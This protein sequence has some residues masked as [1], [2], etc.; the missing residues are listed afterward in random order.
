MCSTWD[1]NVLYLGRK[2]WWDYC[3]SSCS[4][5][6]GKT[7]STPSLNFGL[8]FDN[9]FVCEDE[10]EDLE[11]DLCVLKRIG[12][13]SVLFLQIHV[14]D[15]VSEILLQLCNT[16]R[17]LLT[18]TKEN[19]G[20]QTNTTEGTPLGILAV[21]RGEELLVYQCTQV[22]VQPSLEKLHFYPYL[23]E[24]TKIWKHNTLHLCRTY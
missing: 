10:L 23:C 20:L 8:K 13:Q 3:C 21:T 15:S 19:I 1:E 22:R 4:F 9:I 5:D 18:G 17:A 24:E 2:F 16:K 7:K 12:S 6:R 11:V 14:D